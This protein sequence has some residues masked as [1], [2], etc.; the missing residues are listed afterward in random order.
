MRYRAV[1]SPSLLG[2]GGDLDLLADVPIVV[3]DRKDDMQDRFL[4]QVG[5]SGTHLPRTY[6]PTSDGFERAVVAGLGWGLLPEQQCLDH[7]AAGELVEL[8][9]HDPVDVLLYWQRWSLTSPL[10]DAVTQA[11]EAAALDHLVAPRGRAVRSHL[12][13]DATG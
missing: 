4:R 10:L 7:L 5:F 12:R 13:S 8:A 11:V 9:P 6:V 2:G 1:C 3:F